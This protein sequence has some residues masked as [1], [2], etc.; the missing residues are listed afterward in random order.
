M[1]RIKRFL[2]NIFTQ[3]RVQNLRRLHL[4]L[5]KNEPVLV[6]QYLNFNKK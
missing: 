2:S 6:M 3:K 4:S 1:F 5:V